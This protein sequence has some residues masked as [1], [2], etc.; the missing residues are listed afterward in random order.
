MEVRGLPETRAGEEPA[1][2][3]AWRSGGRTESCVGETWLC[4]T[5]MPEDTDYGRERGVAGAM[6][7]VE[8]NRPG[9]GT[10]LERQRPGGD[11]SAGAGV[12][13]DAA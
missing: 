1:V 4:R 10:G 5:S 7:G 2:R 9:L 11:G 8:A 6:G 13:E 12:G 3:V